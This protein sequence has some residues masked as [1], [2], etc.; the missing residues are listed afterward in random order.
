MS[1]QLERFASMCVL[2]V[3]DME[4][5]RELLEEMLRADGY[6]QITQTCS[7]AEA[8]EA[9]ADNAEFGLVLLEAMLAG[10]PVV[11]T[12]VSAVPEVVSDGES[13][14]LLAP[15][16]HAGI[17][18]ALAALLDDPERARALGLAGLERAHDRFSVAGMADRT[19]AVY[20]AV[21]T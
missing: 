11:A 19:I 1:K 15:G 12:R 14:L 4:D 10:L 5:N 6:T 13:G 16:D 18:D 3:D 7:G 9:L 2:I 21:A 20:G 8:L 17:G